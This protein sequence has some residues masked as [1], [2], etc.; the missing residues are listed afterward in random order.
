MMFADLVDEV[1]FKALLIACSAPITPEQTLEECQ[2]VVGK[3]L[4]E[5]PEMREPLLAEIQALESK[6][7]SLLPEVQDFIQQV[8]N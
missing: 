3:W 2:P 8:L 6:D 1:D 4:Q 5:T 7:Y